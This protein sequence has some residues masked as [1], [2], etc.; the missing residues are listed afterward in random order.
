MPDVG[1]AGKSIKDIVVQTVDGQRLPI[2]VKNVEIVGFKKGLWQ[3]W[4]K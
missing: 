1:N 3:S 4:V 2:T